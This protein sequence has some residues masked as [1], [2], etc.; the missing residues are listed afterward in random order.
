MTTK[1]IR[2]FLIEEYAHNRTHA[3][4]INDH[5]VEFLK[6][7]V[8]FMGT[9]IAF[10]QFILSGKPT[11]PE[12]TLFVASLL[13]AVLIFGFITLMIFANYWHARD[14]IRLRNK[15]IEEEIQKLN[16]DLTRYLSFS[17]RDISIRP[18]FTSMFGYVC[19]LI[20][21]CNL[22][23]SFLTML[24]IKVHHFT[25]VAILVFL[26]FIQMILLFRYRSYHAPNVQKRNK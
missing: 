18:N 15:V 21:I 20:I 19:F 7:F 5:R 23:V 16:P 3:N 6:F 13:F 11:N 22:I 14:F 26:F 2:D 24:L 12:A 8:G 10:S 9:A 4:H 17:K 25:M 1:E